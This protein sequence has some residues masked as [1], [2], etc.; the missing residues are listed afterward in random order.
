[1]TYVRRKTEAPRK[2]R[3]MGLMKFEVPHTLPKDEAKKR[4]T[5]LADYWSSKYGIT[6]NWNG[7]TA[8]IAGKAMGIAI[9]ADLQVTDRTVGG[10]ATDP[11]FLFRDK[12]KKYLTE[13]FT[14][15]LDPNRAPTPADED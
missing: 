6:C 3:R 15:Y 10:E 8:K 14:R 12:A 9:S 5:Q 13:K 1:V 7:D 2:E 11:G 4:I